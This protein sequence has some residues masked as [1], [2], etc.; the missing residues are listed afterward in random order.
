MEKLRQEYILT[1]IFLH[2]V[3]REELMLSKYDEYMDNGEG[4]KKD[5]ELH[6]ILKEFKSDGKDH[7]K[8]LK[9]KMIKLN[10]QG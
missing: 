4:S 6:T 7:I 9:D 8:L 3:E 2:S 5:T 10:I 1:I